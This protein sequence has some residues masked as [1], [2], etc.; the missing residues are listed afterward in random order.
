MSFLAALQF[1]TSI[2][3]PGRHE[4]RPEELAR[5]APYFP[6]IG[7][8][9][10]LILVG[11]YWLLKL[12][13]PPAVVNALIL[14]A[15]VIITGAL[16]LEGFADTCDG[17]AGHKSVEERWRVMRDSRAGAFGVIGVVLLI[18]VKYVALS[19]IPPSRMMLTLLF[20][21]V[22]SRWV[23]VYAIFIYPYARPSGL[24]KVF[25]EGVRW[26]GF[27]AATVITF[28]LALVLI[29][30]FGLVGPALIIGIWL[31]TA[32]VA[33]YFKSKFDGLTGDTYGAVNEVA[34]TGVLLLVV[35]L[36]RLGLA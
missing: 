7:L 23:M 26:P 35:L 6:L 30:V 24:G 25:K 10:G 16:H 13:F 34:E 17:I 8:I 14:A 20:M 19:G 4:P 2:P 9:I 32:A 18:M 15:L 31:L 3:L 21:P 5:A 27:T 28:L 12:I 22:V 1:L 36:A 29:P 33:T 11:L